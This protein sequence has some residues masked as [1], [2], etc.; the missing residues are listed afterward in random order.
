MK[1]FF[2]K[3]KNAFSV[4]LIFHALL[5]LS[6]FS[7]HLFSTKIM[8]DSKN[9]I[10]ASLVT[11]TEKSISKKSLSIHH[12]MSEPS[13][14]HH[15]QEVSLDQTK[16]ADAFLKILHAAIAAKEIY[17]ESALLFHQQ[18][19]VTLGMLIDPIG[20]ISHLTV[21]QSSGFQAIDRAALQAAASVTSLPAA[22]QF[23]KRPQFFS[24]DVIFQ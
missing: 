17:P 16:N 8:L 21:L 4:S 23:L 5:L 12:A 1:Y 18:G 9:I 15:Q 7:F 14:V 22:S 2:E 11:H 10:S 20:N 13:S 3:T 19:T 24:I 6:F